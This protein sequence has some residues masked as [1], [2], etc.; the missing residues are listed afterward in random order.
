MAKKLKSVVRT[1]RV[2]GCTDWD[3]SVCIEKTG[4]RCFWVGGNLCSACAESK[5]LLSDYLK[6]QIGWSRVTFGSSKRTIGI[7]K[8]IRKE[9]IEVRKK[10]DDLQEWI[11]VIILALDGYWRHGGN[12]DAIMNWLINKQEINFK[13]NYPFPRCDN[14]AS[15]H[16]RTV[17][18]N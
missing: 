6:N 15:E 16:L 18:K 2:C 14:E 10:P 3:C 7:I 4:K 9:L 11:D 17:K 8:H 1:C 5:S 12:P 13:R